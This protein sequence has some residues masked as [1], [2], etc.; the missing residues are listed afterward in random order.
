MIRQAITK[1]AL[2]LGLFAM[3][4]TALIA[5]THIGTKDRIA[6]QIRIAREKALLEIVPRSRH[7]NQMLDTTLVIDDSKY[8]NLAE[9]QQAFAAMVQGQAVA[10]IVPVV[11]P[12]GYSGKIDLLVGINTDGS[13]AG[14]RIVQ[15]AETPGLGDK[16]ELKKS[17]WV[18][19]FNDLSIGNPEP[20]GW[21][22]KKDG[23]QFDQFTGATI[24]P[25][26]VVRAVYNALLYY[27]Q[28][29]QALLTEI[30][31]LGDS[32]NG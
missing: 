12:D 26:A 22:V 17:D 4:T 28:H 19:S 31:S 3:L 8:L 25:R 20:E 5:A 27:Q 7:D 13:L 24:T 30:E 11:A 15:H 9:A 32:A 16:V 29:Q 6:E 10:L 18:L 14:V 2:F 23:G 1:N 21:A